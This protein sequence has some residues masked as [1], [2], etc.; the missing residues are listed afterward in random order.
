MVAGMLCF[1]FPF[2]FPV[3]MIIAINKIDKTTSGI[4]QLKQ[5]LQQYGVFLEEFG[6]DTQVVGIS[7]LK[8]NGHA[9]QGTIGYF[10]CR[11]R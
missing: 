3:P 8:V 1:D 9:A 5:Q 10:T 6:G 7:A 11:I 4:S 2:F